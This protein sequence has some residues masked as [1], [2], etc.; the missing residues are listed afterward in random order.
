MIMFKK[1][2]DQIIRENFDLS[3]KY[4]RQYI[5]SLDEESQ[6]ELLAA[7]ST[8]LYDNIVAKVDDIDFGTI[9]MSRGDITKV[10]KFSMT[11]DSL[12]IIRKL[13]IEYKQDP[14]IVDVIIT[15]I[16][17]IKDEKGLYMKGYALDVELPMLIY[18]LMTLAIIR[19]TSMIIATCVKYISDPA[20]KTM[21]QALDKV[22]YNNT[23]DDVMFKQLATFNAICKDGSLVKLLNEA[24]KGNKKLHEDTDYN[25]NGNDIPNTDMPVQAGEENESQESIPSPF[26][27]DSTVEP[28]GNDEAPTPT[29]APDAPIPSTEPVSGEELPAAPEAEPADVDAATDTV[30]TL[31]DQLPAT[32]PADTPSDEVPDGP[33]G[34]DAISQ[35]VPADVEPAPQEEAPM[36]AEPVDPAEAE[37][38]AEDQP[39][40]D[41]TIDDMNPNPETDPAADYV[42]PVQEENPE[43]VEE[44]LKVGE[45][46]NKASN[47]KIGNGTV[48]DIVAKHKVASAVAITAT[49][50][51]GAIAVF[52]GGKM[53]LF[54]VIIPTL[55]N[56]V[57]TFYYTK[58]KISQYWQIQA[59]FL[60]ANADEVENST[61]MDPEKKEK[62][63][64]KQ[65]EWAERFRRWA[66]F[67][68]VDQKQ[69]EAQS[70]KAQN[71]ENKKKIEKND[72]GDDVL[73]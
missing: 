67:W 30:D 13:A 16:Q 64:K 48:S 27:P 14:T 17:N 15:A 22:A 60:E 1:D 21:K 2:Y 56:T 43:E 8:A 25:Y 20:T 33:V 70:N 51:L 49:A 72:D 46:L 62:V 40:V 58:M 36:D 39:P 9:P 3:D 6:E 28:F 65:R 38:P 24:I 34:N 11:E 68:Y 12:N 54:K 5:V 23:Q 55:R 52:K 29:P 59:E 18:N 42:E 4:T 37:A 45:I 10:E 66:N 50:I 26:D 61:D 32:A 71:E 53:L 44:A 31:R 69:A 41:S 19:A 57:Y 73:F 35:E 63:V 47:I 7:L